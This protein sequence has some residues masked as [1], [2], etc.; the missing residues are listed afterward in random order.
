MLD[1][2]LAALIMLESGGDINAYKSDEGAIG[3]LQ[4]RR[5]MVHDINLILGVRKYRHSDAWDEGMSKD[6]ARIYFGKRV[7]KKALKREPIVEDYALA[8]RWGPKG[9]S[10]KRTEAMDDYVTRFKALMEAK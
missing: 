1:K 8:W 6:M 5:I 2:I 4:I 7:T 10:M 3:C 9:P